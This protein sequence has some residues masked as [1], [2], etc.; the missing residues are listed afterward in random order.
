MNWISEIFKNITVSKNL[1][2]ACFLTGISLL[3]IPSYFPDAFE[4]LPKL[5]ATVVLAIVVFSGCLVCFWGLQ[6]LKV[7]F[8]NLVSETV[9]HSRAQ[10]LTELQS[11]II[12]R[13]GDF[14]DEPMDLRDIDYKAAPFTKLEILDACKSLQEKGLIRINRFEENSISLSESGR[15]KALQLQRE[16][17]SK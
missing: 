15:K 14:P 5:W 6:F 13:L 4:S 9:Q 16:R 8:F 12:Y 1:T 17:T 2:G 7:I 10:K 11:V 3:V